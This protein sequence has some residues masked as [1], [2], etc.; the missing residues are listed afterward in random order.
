MFLLTNVYVIQIYE[1][2][3]YIYFFVG[4]EN[5]N[6]LRSVSGNCGIRTFER[7]R[8]RQRESKK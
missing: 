6:L 4:P 3:A 8:E 2:A 5:P 7:V 1:G